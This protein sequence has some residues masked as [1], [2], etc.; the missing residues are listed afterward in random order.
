MISQLRD[1]HALLSCITTSMKNHK[2]FEGVSAMNRL[3]GVKSYGVA[4][5]LLA[6]QA[7][8]LARLFAQTPRQEARDLWMR[9][10]KQES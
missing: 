4:S 3:T 10:A 8:P 1:P 5:R 9:R 2:E 7:W 6:L